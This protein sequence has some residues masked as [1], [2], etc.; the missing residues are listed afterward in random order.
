MK[1]AQAAAAAEAAAAA[2][3]KQA[4]DYDAAYRQGL[5]GAQAA[6]TTSDLQRYLTYLA[7][8]TGY[9]D[10]AAQLAQFQ[11]KYTRLAEQ[12]KAAHAVGAR[13]RNRILIVAGVAVVIVGGGAFAWHSHQ[14]AAA[15][16][17]DKVT[18]QRA[19]NAK[20]YNGLPSDTKK[21]VKTM[22]ATYH[23]NPKDYIYKVKATALTTPWLATPS[24]VPTPAR[25]SYRKAVR[26]CMMRRRFIAGNDSKN[27]FFVQFTDFISRKACQFNGRLFL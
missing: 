9:Q 4:A 16:L 22:M 13:R 6:T 12:E 18:A 27:I 21:D 11:A 26:A 8:F 10:G 5:A 7:Q 19:T 15:A 25:T 3:Q 1:K 17:A 14:A 2:K 24:A 20:S 23:A